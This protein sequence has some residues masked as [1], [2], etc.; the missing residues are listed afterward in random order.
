[1]D[2]SRQERKEAIKEIIRCRKA[3][4]FARAL[5]LFIGLLCRL[6]PQVAGLQP[7]RHLEPP[8]K[9]SPGKT[10]VERLLLTYL[11]S[12]FSP[13]KRLQPGY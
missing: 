11:K 7:V 2:T 4:M 8:D 1:M 12:G 5:P 9:R 13:E 10:A 3:R 6:P